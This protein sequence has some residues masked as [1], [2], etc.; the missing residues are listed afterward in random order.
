MRIGELARRTGASTRA[1]RYYEQRGLLGSERAANGY[2]EYP[3][4]AVE[5]VRGIRL[6][7]DSGLTSDDVRELRG[8]LQ[9][10]LVNEPE[11]EEALALYQQRLRAVRERI[12]ALTA[13]RAR[14]ERHLAAD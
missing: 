13:T 1:L 11:C 14:L 4:E 9:L 7:L 8:C 6:L 10:D 2:R 12:D 5:R 3:P